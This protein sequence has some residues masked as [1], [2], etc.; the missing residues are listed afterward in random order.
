MSKLFKKVAF[1]LLA[2][3][4]VFLI[5]CPIYL[6]QANKSEQPAPKNLSN[7]GDEL[8]KIE[9][10]SGYQDRPLEEIV[11]LVIKSVLSIVG[12]IFLILTV[13]AG[14]VWMTANGNEERIKKAQSTLRRSTIGLSVTLAAYAI[15]YF[16]VEGLTKA[17]GYLGG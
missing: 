15:T 6:A 14:F 1:I 10:S 5:A 4:F 11:G 8:K 12:V 7:A 2:T 13:Y 17:S 3:F 16:V 9:I